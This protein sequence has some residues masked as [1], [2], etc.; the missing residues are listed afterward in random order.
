MANAAQKTKTL[1][2]YVMSS[3]P[4]ADK[5]SGGKLK[6]PHFDYKQKAVDWMK[7]NTPDVYAK[8]SQIWPGWYPSNLLALPMV[9]FI[10]IV[11]IV[12]LSL[13]FFL[14]PR[15]QLDR[16]LTWISISPTPATSGRKPASPLPSSPSP[17]TSSTTSASWSRAC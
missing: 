7:V 6:V 17:E 3:L 15:D 16:L 2:H 11:S 14:P 10:E 13:H 8:M 1:E 4:P 9:K 5:V 12:S